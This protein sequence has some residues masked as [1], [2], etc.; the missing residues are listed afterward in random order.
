MWN[1]PNVVQ[2]AMILP[3]YH[4][5]LYTDA[6]EARYGGYEI[7]VLQIIRVNFTPQKDE[8][9]LTRASEQS[10]QQN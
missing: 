7:S 4:K 6:N 10:L 8:V 5:E 3:E 9:M 2:A 1:E